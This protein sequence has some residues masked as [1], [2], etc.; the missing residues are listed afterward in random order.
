MPPQERLWA[1][2]AADAGARLGSLLP[3]RKKGPTSVDPSLLLEEARRQHAL[4]QVFKPPSTLRMVPVDVPRRRAREEGHSRRHILRLAI[5][6]KRYQGALEVGKITVSR[7]HVGVGRSRLDQVYGDVARPEFASKAARKRVER[8]F[9]HV[10]H[11]TGVTNDAFGAGRADSDDAASR[12]KVGN[13]GLR[14]EHR[15]THVDVQ[16]RIDVIHADVGDR[17][18]KRDCRHC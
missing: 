12:F 9:C 7:I 18:V 16:Q 8:G 14:S 4:I 2:L 5:P 15:R 13:G 17:I 3:G 11:R 1:A 6:A 10:I